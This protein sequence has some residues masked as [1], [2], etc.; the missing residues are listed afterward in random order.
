MS[1]IDIAR[2]RLLG[3]RHLR[4]D[5]DDRLRPVDAGARN[6][7]RVSASPAV[8]ATVGGQHT[9]WMLVTV[10]ARQ[11]AVVHDLEIAVPPL[12]VE[13]GVALYGEAED[14]AQTLV[15][16]AELVAGAAMRVR[17]ANGPTGTCAAEVIVGRAEDRSASG[18]SVSALGSGWRSFAGRPDNSP[19]VLP[20]GRNALGP[21][22]AACLA[23]GEVFKHLR[24]LRE[25]K[26]HFIDALFLSLWDF[27]A[28]AS[29]AELPEGEWPVPLTVPPFYL[30]GCGAV[31]QAVGAALAAPG[32][33]RGYVTTIDGETNDPANLNRYPLATQ[34]D[35]GAS[36]SELTAAFL[37]RGGLEAYAYPGRWPE[38]ASDPNRPPQRDDVRE[39]EAHYRYPL[40]LSC[41]DRN[42]ARHGIQ[43]FWP[44]F[45]MGGSTPGFALEVNAYDMHSPYECLKCFNRPEPAGPSNNEIAAELRALPQEER[46]ARAEARGADWQA[47]EAYLANPKCGRLGAAEISKFR[48][49]A[50]DW[51]VGFLSVAAGT[52]L[53]AQ[54]LRYALIG[55]A[56]FPID[57]GNALRFNFFNPAPRWTKHARRAEC[58]CASAGRTDFERLWDAG[59]TGLPS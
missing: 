21:Y 50:V 19:S 33:V 38:Y 31:G 10:L 14:L 20:S 55:R 45:L 41:V 15:R 4:A 11:F 53:A 52:L 26:G 23:A 44:A 2:A 30:I 59:G 22:F 42:T 28:R 56:A 48:D 17:R 18:F 51:S 7:V 54:L 6:T 12:R 43:N 16:T 8:A 34:A 35:L 1:D 46:R 39:L 9:L 58:D 47:L 5:L 25:G 3:D 37:R 13:P 40:V 27:E 49:E 29:W 24:G 36:K 32:E 57:K